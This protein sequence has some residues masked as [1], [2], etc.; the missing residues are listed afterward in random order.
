MVTDHSSSMSSYFLYSVIF[1][2]VTS[3]LL[4]F[5]YDCSDFSFDFYRDFYCKILND[6][7][8][9]L[10]IFILSRYYFLDLLHMFLQFFEHFWKCIFLYACMFM[11]VGMHMCAGTCGRKKTTLGVIPKDSS[12]CSCLVCFILYLRTFILLLKQDFLLHKSLQSTLY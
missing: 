11:C 9:N 8:F 1:I 10:R 12:L 2:V 7:F 5:S 3:I 4:I 6:V